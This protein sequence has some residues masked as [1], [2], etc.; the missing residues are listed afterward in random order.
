MVVVLYI[1][2]NDHNFP[3]KSISTLQGRQKSKGVLRL[4]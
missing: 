1:Q 4:A 3:Q 2:Q